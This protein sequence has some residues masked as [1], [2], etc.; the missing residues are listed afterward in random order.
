MNFNGQSIGRKME[1]RLER[2]ALNNFKAYGWQKWKS[3]RGVLK[4]KTSGNAKGNLS[5]ESKISNIDFFTHKFQENLH[6]PNTYSYL[7]HSYDI[8]SLGNIHLIT[9]WKYTKHPIKVSLKI[10]ACSFN[11]FDTTGLNLGPTVPMT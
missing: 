10:S 5:L 3:K 6:F 2:P 9:F 4:W 8:T 1:I 11:S 7:F